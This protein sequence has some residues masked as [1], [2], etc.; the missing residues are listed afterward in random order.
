MSRILQISFLTLIF[1]YNLHSQNQKKEF[2]GAG[3]PDQYFGEV[4]QSPTNVNFVYEL[5]LFPGQ[6]F[7]GLYYYWSNGSSAV[8]G[9]F[10]INPQV[11]W[12]T[13]SPTTFTSN[14]CNDIIPISYNFTA[15]TIPGIYTTSIEDL[16]GIWDNTEVTLSVTEQPSTA[17]NL[18]YQVSNGQSISVFDTLSWNGFGPFGCQSNYIPGNTKL[19]SF[20]EKDSV[21]WFRINP[22]DL[23]V[24][25]FGEGVIESVITGDTT[26]NDLVYVI[27]E[28]QYSRICFFYKIQRTVLTDVNENNNDI[29]I[30][31]FKLDQNYPNPF[32]PSTKI[33]FDLPSES[34]VKIFVYNILGERV[35][36]LVNSQLSAGTHQ[37][38]FNAGNLASGIY[39]YAIEASTL[40]GEGNYVSV[41]KMILVK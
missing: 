41:K 36:E 17:I 26:G 2:I 30:T 19:F 37:V 40:S 29:I 15:P 35:R 33:N 34:N 9:N 18:S 1:I 24:P 22:T 16:N 3:A 10:Q 32:N 31:D 4:T 21:S 28:A 14:S 8:T 7:S 6:V 5:E 23:T 25:I 12:L 27:I 39:I 20:R 13:I 38:D 11:S